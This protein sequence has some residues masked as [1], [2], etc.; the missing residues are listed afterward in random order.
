[1]L[2]T[3]IKQLKK[4]NKELINKNRDKLK[5]ELQKH[6]D[7]AKLQEK[8]N[9]IKQNIKKNE[10]LKYE[11]PFLHLANHKA[12]STNRKKSSESGNLRF[13]GNLEKRDIGKN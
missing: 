2:T 9:K 1:M 11:A 7:G 10:M 8:V 6:K 4:E 3:Y 13:P 5:Q 12:K